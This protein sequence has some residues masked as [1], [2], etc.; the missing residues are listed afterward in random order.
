M[1]FVTVMSAALWVIIDLVL[2]ALKGAC[3][4]GPSRNAYLVSLALMLLGSTSLAVAIFARGHQQLRETED[5][6][7][8]DHEPEDAAAAEGC[9][10]S[11]GSRSDSG[12][13]G[14]SAITDDDYDNGDIMA[15]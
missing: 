14:G 5:H 6:E 7:P 13:N 12:S 11:S 15:L 8:E 3:V 10:R 1:V 2:K 9:M 4:W